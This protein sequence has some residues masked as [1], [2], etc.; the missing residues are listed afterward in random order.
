MKLLWELSDKQICWDLHDDHKRFC[1]WCNVT[2]ATRDNFDAFT[3]KGWLDK[4]ETLFPVTDRDIVPCVSLHGMMR[5]T[6]KLLKMLV[7]AIDEQNRLPALES[8]LR[9]NLYEKFSFWQ[10]PKPQS[11]TKWK[12]P[13][14]D[15]DNCKKLVANRKE[16]LNTV[17]PDDSATKSAYLAI[18][19]TWDDICA[20]LRRRTPMSE[21]QLEELAAQVRDYTSTK[22]RASLT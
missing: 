8:F 2:K 10:S 7:A 15:G 4:Q 17:W 3:D 13:R 19:N 21:P 6:E 12:F 1:F 9:D 20:A 14:L 16:L 22:A 18:W 11:L 5:I